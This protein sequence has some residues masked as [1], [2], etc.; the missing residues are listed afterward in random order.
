MNTEPDLSLF[1]SRYWETT[2]KESW[3]K[4]RISIN[5]KQRKKRK[6]SNETSDDVTKMF[7]WNDA[8]AVVVDDDDVVSPIPDIAFSL[9]F[10][11]FSFMNLLVWNIYLCLIIIVSRHCEVAQD[12][13]HLYQST[14]EEENEWVIT[15]YSPVVFGLFLSLST[16]QDKV[17]AIKTTK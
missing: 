9:A 10:L 1:L 17:I 13:K 6:T 14:R 15:K 7:G 16:H 12:K 11:L 2:D 8:P 3:E 5:R 4:H